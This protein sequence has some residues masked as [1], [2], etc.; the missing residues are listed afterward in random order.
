MGYYETQLLSCKLF[1][2][3]I[4]LRIARNPTQNYP[5]ETTQRWSVQ[6]PYW[7]DN[8]VLKFSFFPHSDKQNK[9]NRDEEY[10]DHRR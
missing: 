7:T 6:F 1:S 10:R 3:S 9:D 8:F 4:R 5:I 2:H